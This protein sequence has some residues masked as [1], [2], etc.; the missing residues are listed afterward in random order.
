MILIK[1]LLSIGILYIMIYGIIVLKNIWTK[2]LDLQKTLPNPFGF[3]HFEKNTGPEL[4]LELVKIAK[5]K[6]TSL[7][8]T[9]YLKL[10]NDGKGIAINSVVT[11]QLP[12]HVTAASAGGGWIVESTRDYFAPNGRVG[13]TRLTGDDH[14]IHPGD[15][16]SF[17]GLKIPEQMYRP[18]SSIRFKYRLAAKG[19]NH[20]EGE[21]SG[22]IGH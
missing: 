11:L 7:D 9:A 20:I 19:M 12:E 5:E 18:G 13:I 21:L 2:P 14:V 16:K 3:I 1:V 4:R 15:L 17:F 10:Y 22:A 6:N 8:Y